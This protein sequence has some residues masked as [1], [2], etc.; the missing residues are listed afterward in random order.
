MTEMADSAAAMP[1]VNDEA[2]MGD[3][4]EALAPRAKLQRRLHRQPVD[5]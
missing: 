3:P 4:I 1:H 2:G 5:G